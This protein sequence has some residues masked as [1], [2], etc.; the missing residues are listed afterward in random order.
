MLVL[1]PG[2]RS[3]KLHFQVVWKLLEGFYVAER[4]AASFTPRLPPDESGQHQEHVHQNSKHLSSPAATRAGGC[5]RKQFETV[6][7][8]EG[9]GGVSSAPRSLV[10]FVSERHVRCGVRNSSAC[11]LSLQVSLAAPAAPRAS[12]A[13]GFSLLL[14][15]KAFKT[16]CRLCP[17]SEP[18]TPP[19]GN[20]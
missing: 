20:K 13:T 11:V 4:R 15:H 10:L 2:L 18:L 17:R 9:V 14:C 6:G 3:V 5:E 12:D 8:C 1:I 19:V 16:S 7:K